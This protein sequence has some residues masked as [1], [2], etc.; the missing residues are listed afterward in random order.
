MANITVSSTQ[1]NISVDSTTNTVTVT[2]VPSN[3]T[4]GTTTSVAVDER[5]VDNGSIGGNVTL[6]V[7]LGR[8]QTAAL[9]DNVTGITLANIDAGQSLEIIFTQDAFGG[10][11]LDTTSFPTNWTGWEF[12]NGFT[13]LDTNPNSFNII[14]VIYDGTIYYA[15]LVVEESLLVQTADI[16]DGAVTNSKLAN[17]NIVINGTTVDLGGNINVTANMDL[18]QI[19]TT[20]L[21]ASGNGALSYNNTSGVFSFTPADTSLATKTTDDLTEG[22]TNLYYADSLSRAALSVTQATASGNGTL[23]YSDSTGVFTYLSLIHI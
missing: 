5:I 12:V 23:S 8:I 3:I 14:S 2:S 6:D 21:T 19:S 15:S 7:D 22:S 1:S 16:E 13:D 10:N 20:T 18:T 9:T 4:V 11:T 17:S